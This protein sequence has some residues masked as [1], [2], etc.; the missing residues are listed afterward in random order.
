MKLRQ[1]QKETITQLRDAFR[2]N[3]KRVIMCLPTGAGKTVIFSDMVSRAAGKGTKCLVL[4]DRKELFKQ[5]FGALNRAG[6][7]VQELSAGRRTPINPD[8]PVTLGMVET[9]K[10]R[11]LEN[12]QPDL[13]I[14]DEVHKGN[15]TK[16]IEKF[17]EAKVI[18]ATATPVGKHLPKLFSEII[19]PVTIDELI[20][21]GYLCDYKAFQVQDDFS[22]LK[23]S[24][25][26]YTEASQYAHFDKR[27]LYGNVLEIWKEKAADLKT[28]VFCVNI[29]HTEKTAETFR[30]SGIS[31][32]AVTSNTPK[33]ERKRILKDFSDGKIQVLNNCGILTTGY[34]EPSI[35]CVVMN[36][37]TKSLPLF[38]QCLGR[39]S[40][41][42][43]GKNQFVCLDFG[44]N[45]DEHGMWN[46]NRN[47]SLKEKKKRGGLKEA[48]VKTCPKCEAMLH[49]SALECKYCGHKFPKSDETHEGV[50]VE[51]TPKVPSKLVGR[52]ISD[53][54]IDELIELQ[55][56]KKY[57]A[58]FVWRIM[59][60]HGVDALQEY[61]EKV[62]YKSGWVR[63]HIK[64]ANDPSQTKFNDYLLK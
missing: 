12:F 41:V 48:P 15:F 9:V 63:H 37:K 38:L 10:R 51:V 50:A 29:E 3:H 7:L 34:D 44:M 18:G 52:R 59:R 30:D 54:S 58:S 35:E 26:E 39:G 6:E 16:A 20:E 56:S 4:T 60:W 25:G 28:I 2:S 11:K 47:W 27:K 33:D 13:V 8:Y 45:H 24:R 22:D 57:K 32:A 36:R 64:K 46:E 1:Y 21:M 40:R 31:T 17:P 62:G 19:E 61:A 5:T 55:R 43:P 14:C 49:A 53:L 42:Y 23:S